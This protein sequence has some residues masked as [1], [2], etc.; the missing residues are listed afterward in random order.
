MVKRAL[1]TVLLVGLLLGV[2]ASTAA[3]TEAGGVEHLEYEEIVDNAGEAGQEFLPAEYEMP[4][5][6]DWL[7]IPLVVAG[8]L[9]TALVLL[10]YLVS[11]PRFSKEAEARS[12]R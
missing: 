4:G 6:F 3:A 5:F 7:I 2:M 12:R 1:G 11:Q 10:R 9:I 8:V